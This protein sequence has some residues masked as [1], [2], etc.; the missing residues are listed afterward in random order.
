MAADGIATSWRRRARMAASSRD[1]STRRAQQSRRSGHRWPTD[2][3][4]ELT[5]WSIDRDTIR[6]ALER[7]WR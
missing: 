7:A 1:T 5:I 4:P 6:T 3:T 2:F